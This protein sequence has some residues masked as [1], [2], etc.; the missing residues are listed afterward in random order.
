MVVV[1]FSHSELQTLRSLDC[2]FNFRTSTYTDIIQWTSDSC[3][4]AICQEWQSECE[5]DG[6]E[7]RTLPAP[8]T[9]S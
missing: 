1:S 7:I 3:A 5:N 8:A 6:V 2:D 4:S 9:T